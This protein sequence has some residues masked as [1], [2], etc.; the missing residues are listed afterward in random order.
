MSK[1]NDFHTEIDYMKILK[2]NIVKC[3]GVMKIP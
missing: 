2:R 3:V 1:S